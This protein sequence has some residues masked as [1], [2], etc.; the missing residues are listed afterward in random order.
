MVTAT[1]SSRAVKQGE[2]ASAGEEDS[3]VR[4][5]APAEETAPEA[6]SKR[7]IKPARKIRKKARHGRSRLFT[8]D[9]G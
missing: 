2:R 3:R 7:V 9:N 6:V 1:L 5:T 8:A 4:A